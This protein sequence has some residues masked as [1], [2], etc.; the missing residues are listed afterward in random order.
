MNCLLL[1]LSVFISLP[2]LFVRKDY[3]SLILK[4]VCWAQRSWLTED[5]SSQSLDGVAWLPLEDGFRVSLQ[6]M[7]A[8]RSYFGHGS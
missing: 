8:G 2:F 3:S 4:G 1:F 7:G 6:S 5:F